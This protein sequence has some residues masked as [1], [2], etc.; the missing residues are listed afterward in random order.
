MAGFGRLAMAGRLAATA[1]ASAAAAGLE[2]SIHS[3]PL[4][5]HGHGAGSAIGSR[6]NPRDNPRDNQRGDERGAFP[7]RANTTW[8]IELTS[9][10]AVPEWSRQRVGFRAGADA[11]FDRDAVRFPYGRRTELFLIPVRP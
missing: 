9:Y 11:C 4:G 1:R 3:H 6:D 10:S 7:I 8:S 2:V 5:L